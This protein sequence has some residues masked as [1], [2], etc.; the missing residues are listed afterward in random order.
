M[1]IAPL[2]IA[3][4][5]SSRNL[6]VMASA[7]KMKVCVT[8]A[9]GRSGKL[10][11][12]KLLERQDKFSP[13]GVVRSDNSA[14]ELRGYGATDDQIFVGDLLGDQGKANLQKALKGCDALVIATSAVPKIKPLSILKVLFAKITRQEGVRPE[15]TF[16]ADQTPEQID[17]IGQKMQI[18]AAKENGLKHVVIIS[19]MGGTDR[20]NFLNTIGDGN[21]LVWKRR[22]EKYL[23]DMSMNG[24]LTYT[25]IHPGGLTDD[26]GGDREFILDI[27]DNIINKKEDGSSQPKLYRRIPRSDVAELCVQCLTIPEARGKSL[28]VVCKEKGDAPATTDFV[29]LL[30]GLA[31]SC[32]YEDMKDDEVLASVR[33]AAT[34]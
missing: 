4:R 18:D 11:M 25:I 10:V 22:A 12:K 20:K 8:G 29:A 9:G 31:G 7:D 26:A 30:K 1:R 5:S 15:F 23:V 19:S 16:K 13:V 32:S 3:A 27:D 34:V 2:T 17:W 28:D 24:N 6:I 14:K 33:D 21:I